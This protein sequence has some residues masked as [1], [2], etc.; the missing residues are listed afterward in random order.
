MELDQKAMASP[1]SG[2]GS[3]RKAL[4]TFPR[5]GPRRELGHVVTDTSI[6]TT[7]TQWK[8]A[9]RCPC[10]AAGRRPKTIR[11]NDHTRM[12]DRHATR[13]GTRCPLPF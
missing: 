8:N 6:G 12:D 1:A 3:F 7:V 11:T 2:Q 5:K 10:D 4:C 13:R 9:E